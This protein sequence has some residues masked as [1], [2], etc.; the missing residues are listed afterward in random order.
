MPLRYAWASS[1]SK[2][3]T[4]T[5]TLPTCGMSVHSALRDVTIVLSQCH[6][7]PLR[8]ASCLENNTTSCEPVSK[9]LGKSLGHE[10]TCSAC[11]CLGVHLRPHFLVLACLCFQV[12][13][14]AFELL[15]QLNGSSHY[16]TCLQQEDEANP[17][18]PLAPLR[19]SHLRQ[20]ALRQRQ[21]SEPTSPDTAMHQ[22]LSTG[23]LIGSNVPDSNL[24]QH[25]RL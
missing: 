12:S 14:H 25:V 7:Y 6:G 13:Y 11:C 18:V 17:R 3:L 8:L 4:A 1:T 20:E 9:G 5:P 19:T 24:T 10:S 16:V 23:Y 22:C 2:L 21:L 15:E